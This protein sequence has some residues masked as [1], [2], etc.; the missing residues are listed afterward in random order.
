MLCLLTS[1]GGPKLKWH[2]VRDLAAIGWTADTKRTSP[3]DRVWPGPDLGQSLNSEGGR[4]SVI[5][6]NGP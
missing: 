5:E 1:L 4:F 2:D 6:K 3:E